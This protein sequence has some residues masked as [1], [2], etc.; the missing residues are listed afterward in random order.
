[1]IIIRK[2]FDSHE[3][4]W[5]KWILP[6]KDTPFELRS[7]PD[8]HFTFGYFRMVLED[9]P[10]SYVLFM[11][12]TSEILVDNWLMLYMK[13]S[14]PNKLL[15]SYGVYC[16]LNINTLFVKKCTPFSIL[17]RKNQ[18]C[19]YRC[20]YNISSSFS[21]YYRSLFKSILFSLFGKQTTWEN[22]IKKFF[23]PFPT[24][25]IRTNAFMTPPFILNKLYYWPKA[26]DI[27]S[28]NQEFLFESGIFSMSNQSL[29][30][31]LELY[32]V[33]NNG[34]SYQIADWHHC[35]TYRSSEQENLIISDH[36]SKCYLNASK[37]VRNSFEINTYGKRIFDVNIFL[38]KVKKLN[39]SEIY[40][41]YQDISFL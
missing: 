9:Y 21:K 7:Y 18:F 37:Q 5:G 36:H 27:N 23:F 31:G 33:G 25:Y 34:I 20:P 1:L 8:E 4:E 40:A 12:A 2:G 26:V 15:G 11:S 32:V 22:F 19:Q 10:D 16:S 3:D 35:K 38:D 24:P 41:F 14:E 13:H 28:K 17:A 39:T 29:I 6:F 30:A